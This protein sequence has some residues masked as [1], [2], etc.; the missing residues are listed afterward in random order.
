[1]H[2][3]LP[4]LIGLLCFHWNWQRA[5]RSSGCP[6]PPR[7]VVD[8]LLIDFPPS[9]ALLGLT[10]VHRYLCTYS[11][12]DFLP[13][14]YSVREKRSVVSRETE[15]H[16]DLPSLIGLLYFHWN[17][18]RA[19]RSSGCPWPRR[20]VVDGLLIDFPSSLALLGLTPVHRYLCTYSTSDFLPFIYSVREKRSVVSRETEMHFN[21]P[22]LIGLLYF[23]WNWQR[24]YRSSGCPW[25]R[26]TVVDGL[27]TTAYLPYCS[28]RSVSHCDLHI[29]LMSLALK[30]SRVG[31]VSCD[32]DVNR[33]LTLPL[34]A[35]LLLKLD[36]YAQ[37]TVHPLAILLYN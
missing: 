32:S 30:T 14:I 20:T 15:M 27:M 6:W 21:L 37:D 25:P 19:Y 22:S 9:S 34:F 35:L 7:T 4:S 11:T 23:H 1:M 13:F 26:R 10:P 18:Q 29:T 8:G 3:D 31:Q 12:S 16:F 36:V 17:W 2:F 33:T 24:A 5:Y 28:F